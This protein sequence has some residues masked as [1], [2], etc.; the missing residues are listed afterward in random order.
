MTIFKLRGLVGTLCGACIVTLVALGFGTAPARA[1]SFTPIPPTVK[2]INGQYT[3]TLI[4]QGLTL[5]VTGTLEYLGGSTVNLKSSADL[6]EGQQIII[7]DSW[8]TT[9]PT[10]IN[11]WGVA[12]TFPNTCRKQVL[13]GVSYP[14]CTA[15]KQT[16]NSWSLE[17]TA[18]VQGNKTTLDIFAVQNSNN[19]LVQLQEITTIEGENGNSQGNITSVIPSPLGP[20]GSVISV[21]DSFTIQITSQS[22]TPPPAS[23]FVGT[24]GPPSICNAPNGNND[25]SQGN[26]LVCTGTIPSICF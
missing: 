16:G 18:T 3:G 20:P 6:T 13:S 7:S 14:Q 23:D 21:T 1:Q 10:V 19:Q 5:P 22:T 9:T 17:C 15:W 4:S 24:N 25:N 2:F 12:S 11:E 8:V 26:D